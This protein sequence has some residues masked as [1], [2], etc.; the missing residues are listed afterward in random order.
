MLLFT[1]FLFCFRP[2][3]KRNE[4]LGRVLPPDE[5]DFGR[6]GA[7]A[8]LSLGLGKHEKQFPIVKYELVMCEFF[9][10]CEQTVNLI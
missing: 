5:A 8:T 3:P 2:K 4:N 9:F 10:D 6:K 7:E 1:A